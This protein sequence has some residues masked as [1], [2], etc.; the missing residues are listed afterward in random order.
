[1]KT[2]YQL[3]TASLQVAPDMPEPHTAFYI[4]SEFRKSFEAFQH[5]Q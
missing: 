2:A 3:L 4:K 1:L 5:E